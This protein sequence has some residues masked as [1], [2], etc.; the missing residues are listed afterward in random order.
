[1]IWALWLPYLNDMHNG[2]QAKKDTLLREKRGASPLTPT[3]EQEFAQ[4]EQSP[5]P[6]PTESADPTKTLTLPIEPAP[7]VRVD[8]PSPAAGVESPAPAETTPKLLTQQEMLKRAAAD[9]QAS[10]LAKQRA[11]AD[12][13]QAKQQ[14]QHPHV[15]VPTVNPP[16]LSSQAEEQSYQQQLTA[17]RYNTLAGGSLRYNTPAIYQARPALQQALIPA[18]GVGRSPLEG[19]SFPRRPP[20][21]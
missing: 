3:S 18:E 11:A 20:P 7:Q 17:G 2:I 14:Q 19:W 15:V 8:D 13:Q 10:M 12:L 9:L 16:R 6:G 5:G 4:Q 21:V 1:M